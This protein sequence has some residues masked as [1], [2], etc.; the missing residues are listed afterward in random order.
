MLVAL[1]L[2]VA[3]ATLPAPAQEGGTAALV[4]LKY[5]DRLPILMVQ[6]DGEDLR[7]LVDTAATSMLNIK[8]FRGG[9][10]S[11]RNVSSWSGT[12][13]TLARVYT[14]DE[15]QLGERRLRKLSL[16]GIDLTRLEDACGGKI[17]GIL[18]VDLLERLDVTLDLR[19]RLAV[20]PNAPESVSLK[21]LREGHQSHS[22]ACLSALNVGDLDTLGGC[23]AQDVILHSFAGEFRGRDAVLTYLRETYFEG[24]APAGIYIRDTLLE[25]MPD[26]AWYRFEY[27]V[28]RD[29]QPVM[30]RGLGICRRG[31]DGWRIVLL[32]TVLD[33]AN[34]A[35]DTP[36]H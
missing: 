17:D 29:G 32:H 22:E 2:L 27:S 9:R 35:V 36:D 13:R 31:E 16:P 11:K 15:L 3:V 21:A 5:C 7:F 8:S 30:A 14:L 10:K 34:S 20:I 6:V 26:V 1:P 4:P 25:L 28:V 19:R 33:Y 12:E 24:E 23:L 18:G